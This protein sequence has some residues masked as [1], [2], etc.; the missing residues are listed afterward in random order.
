MNNYSGLAAMF[1][2]HVCCIPAEIT[3]P[4]EKG[5]LFGIAGTWQYHWS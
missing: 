4:E 2:V 5:L 1:Q 3:A